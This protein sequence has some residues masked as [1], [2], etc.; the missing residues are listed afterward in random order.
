MNKSD[1]TSI[2]NSIAGPKLEGA[3]GLMSR[4]C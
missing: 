1:Q 3:L 2:L 4:F